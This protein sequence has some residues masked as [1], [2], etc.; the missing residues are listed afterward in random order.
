MSAVASDD[1][2]H[3]PWVQSLRLAFNILFLAVGVLALTWLVSNI[4]SVPPDMR[5]AVLRRGTLER[6]EN[7]GLLLAWP[8]PFEEVV[9]LPSAERSLE[10]RVDRLDATPAGTARAPLD[11]VSISA[12]PRANIAFFLTGDAGVVHLAAS[13]FYRVSDP[14]AFLLARDGLDGLLQ[15]IVI[16][17]AVGVAAARD[18]DSI[19]VTGPQ[20]GHPASREQLRA[21]LL[22]EVNRRLEA[23]QARGLGVGVAMTRIDL[24][25]ALPSTAQV[26]FDKVLIA[27]QDADAAVAEARTETERWSQLAEQGR[28][29]LLDGAQ[30]SGEELLSRARAR[31]A[32]IS[33]LAAAPDAA[34]VLDRLYFERI[35]PIIAKAR[36]VDTFD[37]AGAGRLILPGGTR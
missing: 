9:L 23:L 26:A 27:T 17:S 33:A 30:A 12:D 4:R 22:R 29:K 16:A 20:E 15:R 25:A 14:A 35:G 36:R 11:A 5:G 18:L 32:E 28:D 10:L 1:I 21:D 2:A 37:A 7:A 3:G 8:R 6:V 19:V 34:S 13:A 31:T 24:V